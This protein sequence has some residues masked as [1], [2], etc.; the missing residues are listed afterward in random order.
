MREFRSRLFLTLLA[1]ASIALL[2]AC[3]PTG[4]EANQEAGGNGVAANGAK[5]AAD[6]AQDRTRLAEYRDDALRG[7]IGGGRER[8]GPNVPVERHCACA[9]D[10]VMEG[11][12]LAELEAEEASGEY[13]ARFTAAMRQC[14]AEIPAD[15]RIPG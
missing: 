14:I 15:G 1:V 4:V 12:T 6:A 9:V 3:G 11:R 7:C 10:R 2:A 13:A 8:A 5:P